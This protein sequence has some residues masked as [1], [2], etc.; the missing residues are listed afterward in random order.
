MYSVSWPG[1][2]LKSYCAWGCG[3]S[4]ISASKGLPR[5]VIMSG[6]YII[7]L[8]FLSLLNHVSTDKVYL[9]KW[10]CKVKMTKHNLNYPYHTSN[11][12]LVHISLSCIRVLFDNSTGYTQQSSRTVLKTLN[13]SNHSSLSGT[14]I[15][16]F[17]VPILKG[18]EAPRD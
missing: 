9:W 16:T 3:Y 1:K 6:Y 13:K 14:Q 7:C 15:I 17:I 5:G 10:I 2:L 12:D 11:N 8:G 18:A 4:P